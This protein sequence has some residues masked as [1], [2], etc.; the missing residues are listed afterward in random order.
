MTTQKHDFQTATQAT[1][2]KRASDMLGY[3]LT[4][5]DTDT[6]MG[7]VQV[8]K[9]RLSCHELAALSFVALMAQNLDDA[10]LTAETALN[11][12]TGGAK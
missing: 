7:T 11:L 10:T 8:F 12:K 6:W 4:L 2:H 3:A 1:D 5:N 9:T